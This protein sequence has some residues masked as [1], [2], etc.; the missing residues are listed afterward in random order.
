[1]TASPLSPS[2][3]EGSKIGFV[4]TVLGAAILASLLALILA[5]QG[6][7]PGSLAVT[8]AILAV[9]GPILA[10]RALASGRRGWLLGT[11][12]VALGQALIVAASIPE[13]VPPPHRLLRLAIILAA[14]AGAAVLA[15][16]FSRPAALRRAIVLGLGPP[17]ALFLA[18]LVLRYPESGPVPVP[19][20]WRALLGPDASLGARL[21]ADTSFVSRYPD[22]GGG[23][24]DAADFRDRLWA[25]NVF[26]GNAAHLEFPAS[27]PGQVRITIAKADSGPTWHIQLN[28][29]GLAVHA[30]TGYSVRLRIRADS[31]RTV[32][33]GFLQAHEPW[34]PIGFYRTITVDTTWLAFND[35]FLAGLDDDDTRLA[36]DLGGS[37]VAVTLADVRLEDEHGAPLLPP[38]PLDRYEVRYRLSGAGCRG[39]DPAPTTDTASRVVLLGDGDAMGIGVRERDTF[40]RRLEAPA[41]PDG[42]GATESFAVLNCARPGEATSRLAARY[43]KLADDFHPGRVVLAI[44]PETIRRLHREATA[45]TLHRRPAVLRLSSVAARLFPTDEAD[46][47]AGIRRLAGEVGDL[48]AAVRAD[49]RGLLVAVLR[50]DQDP[51]WPS[52]IA[53]L[54]ESLGDR[55]V[56]LDVGTHLADSLPATALL[57]SDPGRPNA[58]A[59]GIIADAVRAALV[60]LV[61]T[62]GS[63]R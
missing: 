34:T 55:A 28:Q 40:A 12:L 11:Q 58:T 37:P 13:A 21:P 36:L 45:T 6:I 27:E 3:G 56:T 57:G 30:L 31:T 46:W 61:P 5:A 50:A 39:D 54:R 53:A 35:S 16:G 29:S 48:A 33:V 9:A 24:H 60:A 15:L 52:L 42:A 32:G 26:E 8:L 41:A 10:W 19:S 17:A 59:H 23:D 22:D 43:R 4:V 2:A 7:H 63:G 44:G 1:M 14:L 20:E 38:L 25:L 47:E 49:D 51:G 18:E 62:G